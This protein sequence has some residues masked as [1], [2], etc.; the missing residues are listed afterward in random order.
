MPDFSLLILNRFCLL[1]LT[2]SSP[3][4]L[5]RFFFQAFYQNPPLSNIFFFYFY[6]K[7][8]FLTAFKTFIDF[9]IFIYIYITFLTCF[10]FQISYSQSRMEI[11]IAV[12]V[13]NYRGNIMF[14]IEIETRKVI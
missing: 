12:V 9:L 8:Q 10:R 4:N 5:R 13:S 7:N 3:R 6:L 11:V 1:I 2:C 14:I